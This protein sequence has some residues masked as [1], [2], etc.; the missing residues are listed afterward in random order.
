MD[1]L[2]CWRS[3]LLVVGKS[4]AQQ[5][6]QWAKH[7]ESKRPWHH[8]YIQNIKEIGVCFI[9]IIYPRFPPFLVDVRL[10]H[11]HLNLTISPTS[12][13]QPHH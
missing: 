2:A 12:V 4:E 11:P 10:N 8:I 7:S 9:Y 3:S 1:L 6:C 5:K 13:I